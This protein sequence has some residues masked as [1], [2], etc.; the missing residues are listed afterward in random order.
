[1]QN[2]TTN[3]GRL[4]LG[5]AILVGVS[6]V[7][8]K[9]LAVAAPSWQLR[10]I[11][12]LVAFLITLSYVV[13]RA[14]HAPEKLD[15]W[16]L[17]TRL[18]PQAIVVALVLLGIAS[19]I[20]AALGILVAGKLN[21]EIAYLAQMV[22]YIVS[23]FPQQFFLCSVGLVFLAKFPTLQGTW[24]LPLLVGLLF[25]LAHWWT[26]AKVP[27]TIIPIQMLTTAPAGA[28]AAY[29]F[30]RYR[31]IVP[32]TLIHAVVYILGLRWVEVHL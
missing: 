5:V 30:L 16:G 20:Q 11:D 12:A 19:V 1:M 28:L 2:R 13:A 21:F 29:Y 26:P 15:A 7:A 8:L 25:S 23:A 24:R 10:G 32:L 14:R 9:L 27:G 22:E 6:V 4:D 17:T 3:V 31:S 18:T